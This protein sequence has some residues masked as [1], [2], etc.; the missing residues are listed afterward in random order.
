MVEYGLKIRNFSNISDD[1]LD[2]DVL[3]LTNNYPFCS[4]TIL[5]ESLKESAIMIQRYQFRH[6]MH[7]ISK[8]DILTPTINL[9]NG[10]L[11]YLGPLTATTGYPYHWNALAII[12]LL[13]Y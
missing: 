5:R 3:E 11:L 4:G 12:K 13:Q 8:V 1:Q 9:S 10:T 6:I 7:C 2:P